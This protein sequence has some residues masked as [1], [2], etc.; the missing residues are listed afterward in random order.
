[1]NIRQGESLPDGQRQVNSVPDV[2][3][4]AQ[5]MAEW[6]SCRHPEQ[7][8]T[9][10]FAGVQRQLAGVAAFVLCMMALG[11]AARLQEGFGWL[12][13]GW[14][15]GMGAFACVAWAAR[16]RWR[17]KP[18]AEAVG[19]EGI[20]KITIFAGLCGACWTLGLVLW[21]PGEQVPLAVIG[22]AL[23]MTYIL[24]AVATCFF[25]PWAVIAF[26]API[27]A[28]S[29]YVSLATLR[30]PLG[31]IGALLVAAHALSTLR[32]LKKNW[33]NFAHAIEL[34]VETDR[35][36][37]MLREQ[38][39]IAEKAV[40]LK[41]GFLA[42][43]SHDLRQPMHAISL[44]LDSLAETTELPDRIRRAISDARICAHD[45]NEMFR[46][47]L[48]ISRLDAHQAVPALSTFSIAPLLS[49][50]EKEFL[51]LAISR[52]VTLKVRPCTAHIYSDPVMVERIV[53]N[54]V[55][56]AVRHTSNGR[57]LVG[58]RARGATLRLTVHDTGTGIPESEHEAI[59]KEFHRASS[60]RPADSAGGLGL[61]LA[62]VRRLAQV[63]RLPLHVRSSPGRGS[64]FSVDLPLL[65]VSRLQPDAPVVRSKLAGRLV[66]LV[67]DEP[68]ILQ[69]GMFML[70]SSGCQVIAAR[71]GPEAF[72]LL[73]GSARVP[74]FIICDYEL[75]HEQNGCDVVRQ[76]RE[77]FNCDI[78]AMLV[79]GNTAGGVEES[80]RELAIPV[81]FKPL[82]AAVLRSS[83]EGLLVSQKR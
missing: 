58:C 48:D 81:L 70:E 76:L 26:S 40:Q 15:C 13:L 38:K 49:R 74:D 53:L 42:S 14:Q 66:V 79:T 9:A 80:A 78:P 73:A 35:L 23:S 1:M 67:D 34:D 10:Q 17:E 30:A 32:L 64:A 28:G 37:A 59:F 22:V 69:A 57:V 7:V 45:M 68:S 75:N 82:E 24:H 36:S 29:V 44:Y 50:V 11:L 62:I 25:V 12:N 55:S 18:R 61:G 56:N 8:R 51:P 3:L 71:S 54:F 4:Q 5:S 77:E 20:R 2:H 63:C 39:E 47:L 31:Q 52:G 46:S 41:T 72:E 19:P 83:L 65:Y 21:A 33:K 60:S 6:F 16:S 43:A 27:A